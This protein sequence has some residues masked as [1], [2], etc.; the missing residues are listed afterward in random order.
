MTGTP[1]QIERIGEHEYLIHLVEREDEIEF[2]IRATPGVMSHLGLAV[3]DEPR[4]VAETVAL[5]TERQL[6]ADLPQALDLDDVEASYA[7]YLAV[8]TER[9]R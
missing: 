2:R 8:L 3:D 7:D 4:V 9:L 6:A 1:C 5:L